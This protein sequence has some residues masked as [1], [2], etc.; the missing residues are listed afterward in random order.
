M[1]DDGKT[2]VDRRYLAEIKNMSN[3]SKK[4]KLSNSG[5]NGSVNLIIHNE[6]DSDGK[7]KVQEKKLFNLKSNPKVLKLIKNHVAS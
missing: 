6:E 5:L 7:F 2:M 1:D 3:P 4:R